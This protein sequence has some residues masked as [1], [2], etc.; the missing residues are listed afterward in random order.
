MVR[1]GVR[2]ALGTDL[3]GVRVTAT[4][5]GLLGGVPGAAAS[6]VTDATGDYALALVGGGTYTLSFVAAE[7][8]YGRQAVDVVAP[9][10][11]NAVT[12]APVE[13]ADAIQVTGQ[14]T[15]PGA[16]GASGVYLQILCY[17]CTGPAAT[18]PIAEAVSDTSGRFALSV[19]DPGTGE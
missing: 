18:A 16:A 11:G 10:A 12:V 4:P 2:S 8:D 19:P 3:A 7:P 13:L 5:S 1:G 14:L 17:D 6:V 9:A 15:I